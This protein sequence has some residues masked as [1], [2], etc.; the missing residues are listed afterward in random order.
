[1]NRQYREKEQLN[2]QLKSAATELQELEKMLDAFEKQ[3]DARLGDLLDQ[4]SEL[5]AET[6][7]LDQELR[8]I[9]EQRLFGE[10]VIHYLDGAPRP[11]HPPDLKD[12][13]PLDLQARNGTTPPVKPSALE[14]NSISTD[15][16]TLYRRLA[17]RYHPDLARSDADRRI[18][19][20]HMVEVN[21]AY[22][23]G[24]LRALMH[25]AGFSLP[26]QNM[27]HTPPASIHTFSGESKTEQELLEDKLKA[28]RQEIARLSRL[29]MMKL[30]LD[31]KLARHQRRDLLGEMAYDLQR[32]VDRKTAERDY[33]SSQITA[34]R[35][36]AQ[37]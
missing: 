14:N 32:K 13:P 36:A 23:S 31:V 10:E 35:K 2:I 24:D 17:R 7:S 11:A 15:I 3:V 12:L 5:N 20:Q 9:R 22:S 18:S 30:S 1:M 27:F 29:P 6:S 34:A 37:P 4:L 16:K 8:D 25:L 33:L 26:E 28:V 19:N 21:Q